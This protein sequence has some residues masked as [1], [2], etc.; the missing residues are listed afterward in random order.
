MA[1]TGIVIG[2]GTGGAALAAGAAA[3]A[4]AVGLGLLGLAA[5]SRGRDRSSDGYGHGHEHGYSR[6]R[7]HALEDKKYSPKSKKPK[8]SRPDIKDFLEEYEDSPEALERALQEI[9]SQDLSGCGLKM[10]CDLAQRDSLTVEE[11][12]VLDLVG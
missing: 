5:L 10:M 9:K 12:A 8:F 4:G 6:H 2:I 1:N 11:L 3:T 7:R